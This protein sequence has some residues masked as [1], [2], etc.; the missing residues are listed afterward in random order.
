MKVQEH[1]VKKPRL[2]AQRAGELQ[3]DHLEVVRF[4]ILAGKPRSASPFRAPLS[5]FSKQPLD[6]PHGRRQRAN[7]TIRLA[8]D[9]IV[10]E[11]FPNIFR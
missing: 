8:L 1:A 10:E 2:P 6:V 3:R 4:G 7:R 9:S 5:R 11:Q